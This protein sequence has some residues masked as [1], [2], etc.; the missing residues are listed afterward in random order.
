MNQDKDQ[1]LVSAH[2]GHS[3][4]FC[5][6]ASD[7]LEAI[8]RAYIAQ[9]FE[10]VGLTEHVPPPND[11]FLYPDER[12][13][14]LNAAALQV[15]F[16]RYIQE[17]R[18]LQR[19]YAADIDILVGFESETYSGYRQHIRTLVDTYQPDYIVGSVHHVNDR[20][21]D[22]SAEAYAAVAAELG[23]VD[24]LY[25]RYFDQQYEMLHRLRPQVV[26]HFDYIRIFDPDYATRL[27]QPVIWERIERNLLL[28]DE[29]GFI[30]DFNLR[31]LQK[32]AAEPYVAQPILQRAIE[33]GIPLLPGDDSHSV[34]GAGQ[35]V[36]QGIAWLQAAGANTEW[37]RPDAQ[38]A[39]E[40]VSTTSSVGVELRG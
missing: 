17:A 19:A 21:F 24:A 27:I 40:T 6:H 16:G 1:L 28:I 10:W 36:A 18:R 12:T 8:V 23:S 14:G 22:I 35:N 34:A 31:A 4:E 32:G 13:A 20:C 39:W 33:L 2:G 29:L 11:D 38:P 26:G 25:L 37:V 30:L 15:R 5:N 3:G 7:T 9:G